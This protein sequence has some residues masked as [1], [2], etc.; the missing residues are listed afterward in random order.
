MIQ[1]YTINTGVNFM[2]DYNQ[3]ETAG[4][5]EH[6]G[7]THGTGVEFEAHTDDKCK[8]KYFVFNSQVRLSGFYKWKYCI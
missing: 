5:S 3:G 7:N 6:K 4:N 8:P 1:N 2:M